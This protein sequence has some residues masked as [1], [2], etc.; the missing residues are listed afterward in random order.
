MV[1][2]HPKKAPTIRD[3]A[4]HAGLSYATVSR[5]LNNSPRVSE[6]ARER[7]NQAIKE[8]GFRVNPSAR[9]LATGRTGAIGFVVTQSVKHFF[10]DPTFAILLQ[11]VTTEA[12]ELGYALVLLM[13]RA[14][15]GLEESA[16]FLQ[17]QHLDGIVL[18][19]PEL[20]DPFLAELGTHTIPIV[21]CG[22][23][24][25]EPQTVGRVEIDDFAGAQEVG[26]LFKRE[27]K[28]HPVHITGPKETGGGRH[29]KLGFID[30]WGQ[31]LPATALETG[32]YLYESG[33]DA[34]EV[35]LARN[36]QLDAVFA[37]NDAMAVGA[38]AVLT[39]HGIR[40]PEDVAVVGFDDH[41]IARLSK[42]A[43]TTIRQDIEKV[44]HEA[45]KLLHDMITG[46]PPR[47]ITLPVELIERDTV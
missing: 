28:R 5:V 23:I 16:H 7:V 29:R 30:G 21:A 47:T 11:S 38:I 32:D 37:A 8:T 14:G 44:G 4:T 27:G 33:R 34:M 3:V 13:P 22:A 45:A 39:E 12:K 46:A 36:P 31:N 9:S 43:L 26:R 1:H 42:P 41:S 6:D 20:N 19:T 17:E 24:K 2:D 15:E 25:E 40:V 10:T 35:L 18:A